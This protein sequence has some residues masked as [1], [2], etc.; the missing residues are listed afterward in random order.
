MIIW[1]SCRSLHISVDRR[2]RDE[3]RGIG[4]RVRIKAWQETT[5]GRVGVG[6]WVGEAKRM[7]GSGPGVVHSWLGLLSW[8]PTNQPGSN[9]PPL[10]N[11]YIQFTSLTSS[12]FFN[13]FPSLYHSSLFFASLLSS[14]Y[15]IALMRRGETQDLW[16]SYLILILILINVSFS[17]CLEK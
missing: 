1:P 15:S 13:P 10:Q 6:R 16:G 9:A 5:V 11:S 7:N 4:R 17:F 2:H 12:P 14:S 8:Q 3:P